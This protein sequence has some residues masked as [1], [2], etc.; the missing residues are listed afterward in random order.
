MLH[1]FIKRR[2]AEFTQMRKTKGDSMDLLKFGLDN[3]ESSSAVKR[4]LAKAA[5]EIVK[6][7]ADLYEK[8]LEKEDISIPD[9]DTEKLLQK[10]REE[11]QKEEEKQQKL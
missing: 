1:L 10:I 2:N 9:E 3:L 7:Q 8:M 4:N 5:L 11:I 6:K